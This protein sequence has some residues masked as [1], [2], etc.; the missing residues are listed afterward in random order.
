[1]VSPPRAT[2]GRRR[3]TRGRRGSVRINASN[4]ASAYGDTDVEALA[5]AAAL[6]APTLLAEPCLSGSPSMKLGPHRG[7]EGCLL[8]W[9]GGFLFVE[10]GRFIQSIL[11]P[12]PAQKMVHPSL[13]CLQLWR[14]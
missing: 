8:M 1:M 6:Y 11:L 14:R 10:G 4:P 3:R 12:L 9:L 2:A 13:V 7:K 5:A